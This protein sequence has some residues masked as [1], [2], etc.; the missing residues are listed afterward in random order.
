M[1]L[2]RYQESDVLNALDPC[3]GQPHTGAGSARGLR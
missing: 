3:P 2:L 1:K